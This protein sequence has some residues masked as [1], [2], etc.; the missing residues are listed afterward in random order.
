MLLADEMGL[1]KTIQAIGALRLLVRRGAIGSALVV[2]PVGVLL[3]W[4]QQFRAW[5]PELTLSTVTGGREDR[6]GRWKAESHVHL[7]G[8]EVLRNDLALPPPFGPGRRTW[9]V[10]AADEAQRIKNEGTG[11]SMALKSL[12]RRRSWALTGTPVEN[13]ALDAASILD[14]VAP[15]RLDRREMMVGLRRTLGEVQLRRRRATELPTL[16]RK[17]AQR[18]DVPLGQEQRAA[19]TRAEHDGLVWLASLGM[20]ITIAHM[21]ELILRLKQV[22]NACP[23]TGISAKADDL[24]RR[25]D[26]LVAAG[27]KVLVFSQFVAEP[28]GV[29][30]LARRLAHLRPLKLVGSMPQAGRQ[31]TM[32]AFARDAD[33]P[34]MVLSLRA[35]GVGLNLT[36]ASAVFH[37][38]RWWNPAVEAQAEDRA[39]RIGQT[40]PVR[41]FGYICPGT[42]EERIAGILAEKRDLSADLIDDV[43]VAGLRRLDLRT[44]LRAVGVTTSG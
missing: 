20:D 18:V 28:F 32:E 6:I 2:A 14:F 23:R 11:L 37:F 19:Y 30:M 4:R 35:G 22:C 5:A 38:D 26:A 39:H 24:V 17:T 13:R 7:V 31:R 29:D 36:A 27:E 34:V 8:Y 3:Q 10:V 33:R 21:L 16:P 44:L 12:T 9:D 15:G 42:V 43:P 25:V 40:R 41:T 1:G